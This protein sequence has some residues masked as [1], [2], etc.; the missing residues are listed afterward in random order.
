MFV[1]GIYQHT[2]ARKRSQTSSN[3]VL[4]LQIR[5]KPERQELLQ[6]S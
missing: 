3:S 1:I 2:H 5:D 6:T 4:A